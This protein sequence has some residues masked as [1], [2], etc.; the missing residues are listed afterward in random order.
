MLPRR[1]AITLGL[2]LPST[3]AL[4]WTCLCG[5]ILLSRLCHVSVLWADEDYHLAGAIQ[6]LHGK[7]PYRDFWYDK[8]PLNLA[9]YL[10]FGAH[11][12][13]LLRLAGSLFV[14][15][16]CAL[17]YRFAAD[18]WSPREGFI[19]ASAL[20][21]SLI[22]YLPSANLPL[23]P[24]TLAIAPHL[25]AVYLAWRK[26]PLAA[27]IVAG[28]A[29]L[30][31]ARALFILAACALF[32]GLTWLTAGFLAL[33]LA[34]AL[35]LAANH[36]LSDYWAQVW[37]WGVRYV[38]APAPGVGWESAVRSLMDWTGFHA[39]LCIGAAWFFSRAGLRERNGL[40]ARLLA[41]LL[42]SLAGAGLGLRFA[43]RY[44]NQLLPVLAIVAGRGLAE[45]FGAGGKL[46]AATVTRVLIAAALIVAIVRFGPAYVRLAHD[47]L[48]GRGHAWKDVAMDQESRA[49]ARI[50]EA[51]AHPGDTIFI[52]GYRPNVIAYTRLPVAGMFW[53]S[54]PLDGV[55]ADRHLGSSVP[56]SAAWARENRREFVQA[57]AP[58]F[59]VDGL[60]RY[61]PHLD[62]RSFAE[63]ADWMR[64]YCEI[65][66]AGATTVYRLCT[67]AGVES[68]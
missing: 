11:T 3:Q 67:R 65:G 14:A 54:Q 48:A 21:F 5:I 63:L 28:C 56:V 16:C 42:I 40:A 35:W 41:W 52:W 43:P 62:I 1:A 4:F 60:S 61:N 15:L 29:F 24:D 30:L 44:M 32:G 19:A 38:A 6:V 12:G 31:N 7:I 10:L 64:R 26:K 23:E 8:P 59:V 27:G 57:P 36:A 22:F 49:A 37:R 2:R 18:L 25:A 58:V 68:Q 17:A 13:V 51:A 9:P 34:A 45:L 33:N 20:A 55:P 53:D 46:R 39:A 66:R 50:V 47:D